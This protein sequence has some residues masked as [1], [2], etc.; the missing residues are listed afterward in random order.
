MGRNRETG[1]GDTKC[2][3]VAYGVDDRCEGVQYLNIKEP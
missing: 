1:G 3:E 2:T